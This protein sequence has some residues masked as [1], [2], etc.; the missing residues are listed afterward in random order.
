M[1]SGVSNVAYWLSSL[2]W[3]IC[4]FLPTF[5]VFIIILFGY[6]FQPIMENIGSMLLVVVILWLY[7]IASLP[8]TYCLSF[9][10]DSH[11]AAQNFTLLINFLGSVVLLILSIMLAII[12]SSQQASKYLRYVF[13]LLPAYALGDAFAFLFVRQNVLPNSTSAWDLDVCGL[14]LIFLI[15][16]TIIYT[17]LLILLERWASN[18][19]LEWL[20]GGC[21]GQRRSAAEINQQHYQDGVDDMQFNNNNTTSGNDINDSLLGMATINNENTN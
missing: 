11:T 2:A 17:G 8:F 7:I 16:D 4:N 6:D 21:V 12:K 19:T 3:D 1:V 13:R 18:N 10:F 20:K 9:L 15:L 5:G 14:D